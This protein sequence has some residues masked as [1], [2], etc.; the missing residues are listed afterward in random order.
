ME[1]RLDRFDLNFLGEFRNK[2]TETEFR[3]YEKASSLNIVRFLILM[4]GITFASF[5]IS[6]YLYFVNRG[7]LTIS[8]L[9]RGL[10]LLIAVAAFFLAGKIRNYGHF[11]LIIVAALLLIFCLFLFTM[12][13]QD[14]M[15]PALRFMSVILFILAAFLI[16]NVW[17]NSLFA[18]VA[19]VFAYIG[20]SVVFTPYSESP[21][22]AR[23]G[24]YLFVCL[25]FCAI[26]V[27]GRERS[28]RKHFAAEKQMELMLIT[29]RL[30]GIYNRSRFEYILDLWIKNM[31]HGLFCLIF[32]DIDNFKKVN[33]QFGHNIGDKVLIACAEVVNANIRDTDVFA[34]W[35]GEEF[36]VLFDDVNIHM[37]VELAERL[38][39]A[40]E[41][42]IF[43]EVGNVTISIG[44]VE[45]RKGESMLDLV[46][47]ADGKMYEAKRA[48]RNK[49]IG[50]YENTVSL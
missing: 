45:Y 24:I 5:F 46:E 23:Q 35:G 39:K 42:H 36:V 38:R 18:S 50:D 27:Y 41:I 22:L 29:D 14:A 49:V 20:F 34:R 31:R 47:R 37:G 40:V 33:D 12:L 25:V 15:E 2:Q 3:E 43:G 16:P 1:Q 21:T 4:V 44:V 8:L 11:L 32:F 9:L 17:K 30:T 19:I 10:G 26:F 28:Q 48:G 7:L 13:L 6:D